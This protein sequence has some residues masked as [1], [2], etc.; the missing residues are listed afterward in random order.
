[1]QHRARNRRR[2]CGLALCFVAGCYTGRSGDGQASGGGDASGGGTDESGGA[3]TTG[4]DEGTPFFACDPELTPPSLPL[5]RLSRHQYEHA[6]TDLVA[7]MLPSEAAA[8]VDAHADAFAKFPPD[9]VGDY[10]AYARLDQTVHQ[11]TVD[12]TYAVATAIA[13]QLTA[14]DERLATVVGAC[15]TNDDAA[16]DDACLDDFIAR[17]GERALRRAIVADDVAFYRDVAAAPPFEP[18]DYADVIG[19]L[20]MAPELVYFVEHGAPESGEVDPAPLSSYELASRLSFHFW[21]TIPDDELF[22]AAR[23]GSLATDEGYAAQLDRMVGDPRTRAS[24]ETFFAEWLKNGSLAELD[25]RLGTPVFDAFAGDFVPGPDLRERMFQ[26]VTDLGLHYAL[27]ADGTFDEMFASRLSFAR[28]DDLAQLY[29][30][31]VWNGE[32]TP[33]TFADEARVGL[34]SRAALV[35]TG[36]A[37]TR[38]IMKGV[39]IRK[40]LL[41][42]EIPPPPDNA[43]AN[44]PELSDSMTTREVVEQLTE[45]PGSQCAGCH[46]TLINPLGF[47][48]ENFD[49]LG[50]VRDTQ[51]LYDPDTAAIVDEKPI[52]T[53]SVPRLDGGDE[54]V[55]T[56]VG[57]LTTMML[58]SGA[59]QAC[60]VRQYHRFTF[61]R[62]EDVV[63]DG[64]ALAAMHQRVVDG[65]PIAAVL[66]EV[67][68]SDAFR[69]RTFEGAQ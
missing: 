60:F 68:M 41:C 65:E 32:G 33:P 7:F 9:V 42:Q 51:V 27:D 24:V 53:R 37:N 26:E 43:A 11:E 52:D 69:Q 50:R 25:S 28:T 17:L 54:T 66:R 4:A 21:Q 22:A 62:A 18:A 8:I 30:V 2:S 44:P 16:D 64:C 31:E 40:G 67:A 23:D 20:L 47:A 38:P 61:G 56:G 39:Y 14:S 46:A 55:S 34:L 58:D 29:G 13:G 12:A 59:P 48:T 6:I 1:M 35:A 3:D 36:S 15:A 19:M 63:A 57:D 10:G 49:A 45:Q 5:R